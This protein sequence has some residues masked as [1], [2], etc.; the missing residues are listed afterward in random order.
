[1]PAMPTVLSP[2]LFHRVIPTQIRDGLGL[3]SRIAG[4]PSGAEA[5]AE[6][7]QPGGDASLRRA[8]GLARVSARAV[9][10]S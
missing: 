1:M 3:V 7:E 2:T 5:V 4:S 9:G 10:F 8:V 6:S